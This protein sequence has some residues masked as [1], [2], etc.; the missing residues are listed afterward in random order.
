M[1]QK[2][3]KEKAHPDWVVAVKG[4]IRIAT[5]LYRKGDVVRSLPQAVAEKWGAALK[6]VPVEKDTVKMPK[7]AEPKR[8]DSGARAEKA[9]SKKL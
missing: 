6:R 8:V 2:A 9:Q 1:S 4:P 5:G 7:V 3:L